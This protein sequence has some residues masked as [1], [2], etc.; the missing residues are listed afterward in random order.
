MKWFYK[1]REERSKWLAEKFYKEI[2]SSKSLLDVG[3]YTAELKKHLPRN[4]KYIGIDIDGFPDMFINLDEIDE[5]PFEDNS[6]DTVVCA[7]VLEHLNNIHLIFDELCRITEKHL[8][9][10][11]PNAYAS[12]P[13]F[14]KGKKY[15]TNHEKRKK[16]GK[17]SKYYGLPLEKPEDRHRWF[18]SFDEAVEFTKFRAEKFNLSLKLVESEFKYASYPFFRKM[19]YLIMRKYNRN[20]VDK[21]IILFLS[22]TK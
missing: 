4:I 8:I 22:K 13:E 14:I 11:L 6:F 19:I 1:N 3:C 9:I 16:H 10:T 20:L 18:F 12:I 21:H 5:L 17:Y 7:D 15:T 2:S